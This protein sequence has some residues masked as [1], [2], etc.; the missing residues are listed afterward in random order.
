MAGSHV[1]GDSPSAMGMAGTSSIQGAGDVNDALGTD[2]GF[3]FDGEL[4]DG[5]IDIHDNVENTFIDSN[6]GED[7]DVQ[8]PPNETGE[9]N[10]RCVVALG[11]SSM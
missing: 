5:D 2:L 4:G 1:L 3:V 9:G 6:I 8:R 10:C 7:D 11:L